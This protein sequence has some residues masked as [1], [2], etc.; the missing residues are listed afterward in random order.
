LGAYTYK[1]AG[2]LLALLAMSLFS[3]AAVL[4]AIPLN[5]FADG[6][7]STEN[8]LALYADRANGK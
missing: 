4:I 7:A 3:L 6:R 5:V 2:I 1:T 8:R